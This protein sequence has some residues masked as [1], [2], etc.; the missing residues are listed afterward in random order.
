MKQLK[1]ESE[2]LIRD[3]EEAI[4][5]LREQKHNAERSLSDT[6]KSLE[7][8]EDLLYDSQ[9]LAKKMHK[10]G[11]AMQL[12]CSLLVVQCIS[13]VKRG[14]AQVAEQYEKRIHDMEAKTAEHNKRLHIQLE[15]AQSR[16]SKLDEIK[17]QMQDTLVNHKREVLME[18]KVQSAVIHSDLSVLSKKKDELTKRYRNLKDDMGMLKGSLT[19]L[20]SQI[21]DASQ[22][23]ALSG[24]EVD[25]EMLRRKRRLDK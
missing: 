9:Q 4:S 14:K 2:A 17:L 16:A 23:S 11:T 15:G 5:L 22:S 21:R 3:F 6:Q 24:G 20:E 19:T 12:R 1:E 18:H 10:A 8:T 25:V 13:A 7:E